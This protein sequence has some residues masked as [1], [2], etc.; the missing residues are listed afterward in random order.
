LLGIVAGIVKQP[1]VFVYSASGCDPV[2]CVKIHEHVRQNLGRSCAIH[3]TYLG[4][5]ADDVFASE[6]QVRLTVKREAGGSCC[7]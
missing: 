3:F 1:E 2:G 6:E 7:P 5:P 4:L